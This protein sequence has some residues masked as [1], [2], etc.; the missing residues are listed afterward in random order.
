[1][2]FNFYDSE[3]SLGGFVRIGNRPNERYAEQT[4]CLYLPDGRVGFVFGR[5]EISGND[6]FRAGGCEFEVVTP[7]EQLD[8]RY[9]GK[10]VL[11]DE[12]EAM[13]DPRK[14]FRENPWVEASLDLRYRGL[15]PMYGGEPV[16]ADGNPLPD[17]GNE[18]A[19]G[20]Y[21]QHVGARGRVCVGDDHWEVDAYGLRDHSW[22]P[23]FW[24][25]PWWYRWLTG[26]CGADFGFML[27]IIAGRDG[28]RRR[29]GIIFADGAYQSV[30]HCSI[31]TGWRDADRYHQ[32]ITATARTDSREYRISGEV[33]NLIPL[34]NRRTAPDGERLQTRISEGMTRW[35]VEGVGT[36]F[37]LS[38]YLDQIVDGVPV[39]IAEEDAIGAEDG[40]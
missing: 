39:G 9:A 2:Y 11:L 20:H 8:V 10:L 38:E 24:Q 17:T 19:K 35:Q 40:A 21:E 30:R 32:R 1:M 36:G 12:P 13:A 3:Q 33:M 27:S 22:G 31:A 7:F 25:A 34:R 16:D 29:G 23:R 37:G 14:A 5:P 4:T 18:F 6:R 15:S 26:N 28:E